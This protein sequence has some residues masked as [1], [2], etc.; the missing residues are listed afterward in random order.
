M[1]VLGAGVLGLETVAMLQEL[2]VKTPADGTKAAQD[3]DQENLALLSILIGCVGFLIIGLEGIVSNSLLVH[4]ANKVKIS[5]S[6]YRAFYC[7]NPR[8]RVICSCSGWC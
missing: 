3:I 7:F 2:I 5:L 6:F 8:V 1:T 4:G